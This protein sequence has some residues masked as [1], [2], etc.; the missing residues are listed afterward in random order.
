MVAKRHIFAI[1]FFL[2]LEK[3][4]LACILHEGNAY[5]GKSDKLGKLLLRCSNA[6]VHVGEDWTIA[7]RCIAIAAH[8]GGSFRIGSQIF[9]G[10]VQAHTENNRIQV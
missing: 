2:T 1:E 3:H 10:F 7:R 5:Q 9:P 4:R 6:D 8:Q